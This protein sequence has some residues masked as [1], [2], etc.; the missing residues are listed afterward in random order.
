MPSRDVP[1]KH[2][3][4]VQPYNSLKINCGSNVSYY[5]RNTPP[6]KL[7]MKNVVGKSTRKMNRYGNLPPK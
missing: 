4:T 6:L 2:A 5:S 1:T 3:T 7:K